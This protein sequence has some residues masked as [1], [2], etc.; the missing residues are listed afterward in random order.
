MFLIDGLTFEFTGLRGFIAQRPV[1]WVSAIERRSGLSKHKGKPNDEDRR[2]RKG[3]VCSA[4]WLGDCISGGNQRCE[5][6]DPK[7][8]KTKIKQAE[9]NSATAIQLFER[10][11]NMEE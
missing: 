3:S 10:E 7:Y 5:R 9:S 11:P 6:H 4:I 1:E 2:K 8:A